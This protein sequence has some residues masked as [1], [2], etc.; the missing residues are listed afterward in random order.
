MKKLI[1]RYCYFENNLFGV[2]VKKMLC[3]FI[4]ILIILIEF[5]VSSCIYVV[6]KLLVY[7]KIEVKVLKSY[8]FSF[9][10]ECCKFIIFLFLGKFVCFYLFGFEKN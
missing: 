5:F 7:G 3:F 10:E 1:I 2:F 8:S 9:K 6:D 4:Y